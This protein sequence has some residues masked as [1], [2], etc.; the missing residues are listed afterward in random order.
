MR[1]LPVLYLRIMLGKQASKRAS[2]RANERLIER[3]MTTHKYIV[4]L[5][6]FHTEHVLKTNIFLYL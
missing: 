5:M 4:V 3:S 1:L 2:K 6:D